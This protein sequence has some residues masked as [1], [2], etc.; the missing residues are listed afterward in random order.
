MNNSRLLK[1]KNLYPLLNVNYVSKCLGIKQSYRHMCYHMGGQHFSMRNVNSKSQEDL[2]QL[3]NTETD[4]CDACDEV[5]TRDRYCGEHRL[6]LY[7]CKCDNCDGWFKSKERFG[8][9]PKDMHRY[10]SLQM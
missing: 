8:A 4:H 7:R 1:L 2:S 10:W 9:A 6:E 3:T 5:F